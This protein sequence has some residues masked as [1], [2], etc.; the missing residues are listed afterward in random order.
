MAVTSISVTAVADLAITKTAGP[1]PVNAGDTA[2]WSVTV[3]NYGPSRAENV[4]V[5]DVLPAG[6][7]GRLGGGDGPDDGQLHAGHTG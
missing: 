2:A 6:H 1:S 3:T 5:I 7:G 4:K